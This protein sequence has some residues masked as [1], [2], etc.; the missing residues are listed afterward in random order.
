M[1][2]TKLL[3]RL[4]LE[5]EKAIQFFESLDEDSWTIP[6]YTEGAEWTCHQIL[7]HFVSVERAFLWLINNIVKG[8]TGSPEDFDLD[9][10]NRE[11]VR[12][13]QVQSSNDL[14]TAFKA[15]RLVTIDRTSS[16][17]PDD[18][19][20]EGNH[21]WFGLLSITAILRL[22]YQHNLLHIRDIRRTLSASSSSLE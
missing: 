7:A 19:L 17:H 3:E 14:L 21:P 9:Q 16:L 5:G 18:L 1:N 13:L 12:A 20:K 6:I 2:K 10:F 22:L 15:E 4:E 11:E 8:G